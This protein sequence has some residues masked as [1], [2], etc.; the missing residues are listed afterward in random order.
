MNVSCIP[1]VNYF[2]S[3]EFL[4]LGLYITTGIGTPIHLFGL[5]CILFKTT[6]QM[7][8]VK[9]YLVNLHVSIVLFDYSFGLLTCPFVLIPKL[10]GYPLGV[11]RHFGVRNRDQTLLVLV[12]FACVLSSV[13]AIFENRYYKVCKNNQKTSWSCWRH[14]WLA[15][16]YIIALFILAPFRYLVPEQKMARKQLF[17]SLPCLP[18]Y[19]Y[20]APVFVFSDNYTYILISGTFYVCFLCFEMLLFSSFLVFNAIK[21]LRTNTISQKTFQMQRNFFIALVIQVE[22]PFV[23]LLLP[24]TYSWIAIQLDYYNQKMTNIAILIGS[25]HGFVSTLVMLFVHHPYRT[26]FL[27]ILGYLKLSRS[28][29]RISER[30]SQYLERKPNPTSEAGLQSKR[31][32]LL[33]YIF[34]LGLFFLHHASRMPTI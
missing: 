27:N 21:Q 24:L 10:A 18:S 25:M 4:S 9:W 2:D 20:E 7:K 1:D 16:H 31:Q 15:S 29:N 3:P 17:E 28:S 14:P 22:I 13:V 32:K 34:D 11:L 5:Y 6:E 8:N 26:A 12:I 30:R 23:M 19:I 33:S